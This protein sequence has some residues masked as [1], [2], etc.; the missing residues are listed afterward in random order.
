MK[1]CGKIRELLSPYL[2]N[3]LGP[4]ELGR[5]K[6]HLQECAECRAELELLRM[7]VS[8]LRDLPELPAPAGILQGVREGLRPRP[9]HERLRSLLSPAPFRK[10]PLGALASVL[11]AFGI[12]LIYDRFPEVGRKPV[13]APTL[14]EETVTEK[15]DAPPAFLDEVKRQE[16][17]P[18]TGKDISEPLPVDGRVPPTASVAVTGG[19]AREAEE[20]RP[21]EAE[22]DRRA[23]IPAPAV[24]APPVV[25]KAKGVPVE[26]F[27]E[28][29]EIPAP[30][31]KEMDTAPPRPSSSLERQRAS[32]P[33]PVAPPSPAAPPTPPPAPEPVAP[34]EM[35]ISAGR[36]NVGAAVKREAPARQIAV[37]EAPPRERAE[38][39]YDSYRSDRDVSPPSRAV[40]KK[41]AAG[42]APAE[43]AASFAD[44]G[45]R[46]RSKALPPPAGPDDA[47][48]G[49]I[50]GVASLGESSS[51]LS[52]GEGTRAGVDVTEVLTVVALDGGEVGQIRESLR[53]AG[54][55]MLELRTLDAFTSQQL[56]LPHRKRIPPTQTISQGWQ[57]RAAVPR[58][59]IDDFV[60]SLEGDSSLQLLHRTTE[61]LTWRQER[62]L[63]N[64]E[65]KL[66][67]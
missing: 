64:F 22:S 58:S 55:R 34:P 45:A 67:R 41:A 44:Q 11:V 15:N 17:L 40:R 66:I 14:E 57:I 53:R 18:D 46:P 2:E 51:A 32:K 7:T 50:E 3:E 29:V 61:P 8:A 39:S 5:V 63:Q 54:G 65:I 36:E 35:K 42:A 60:A 13:I 62:G 52:E 24:S 43:R 16:T 27:S 33:R 4:G 23:P 30:V 48:V 20:H 12:F 9:W 10:V 26:G 37:A 47:V 6:G 31:A 56:A 1:E 28:R 38:E 19:I 49:L 25:E 59:S 21:E